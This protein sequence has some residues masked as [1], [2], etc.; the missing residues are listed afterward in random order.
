MVTPEAVR[1]ELR[2]VLA[3]RHFSSSKRSQQFLQYV[4]E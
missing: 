4:V 1:K 2:Q 3:S